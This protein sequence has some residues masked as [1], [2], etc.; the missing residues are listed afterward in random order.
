MPI[1]PKEAGQYYSGGGGKY[2]TMSKHLQPGETWQIHVTD[3]YKDDKCKYPILGTDY[4]YVLKFTHDGELFQFGINS[5]D[6]VRQALKACYPQGLDKPLEPCQA[7]L[8]RRPD[9]S[10]KQ[11]NYEIRRAGEAV[12]ESVTPL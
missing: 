10:T 5:R 4:R 6:G 7:T 3:L 1:D 12:K 11:A 2:L 8:H 9:H